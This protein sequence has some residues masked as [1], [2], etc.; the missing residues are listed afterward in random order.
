VACFKEV[1]VFLV[2]LKVERFCVAEFELVNRHEQDARASG[3]FLL[4]FKVERLWVV[5][6]ELVNK[7]EQD[8]R[9]SGGR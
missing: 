5:E 4:V 8:A 3:G 7:H 1:I 2:S 9:A 6:F